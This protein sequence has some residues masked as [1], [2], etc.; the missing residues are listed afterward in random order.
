MKA[1][2]AYEELGQYAKALEAYKKIQSDFSESREGRSIEKY[3][4]RV[5]FLNKK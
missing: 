5:E 4:A 1:G 2:I 3:I